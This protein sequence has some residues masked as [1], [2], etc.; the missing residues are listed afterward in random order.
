MP[1]IGQLVHYVAEGGEHRPAWVI[2]VSGGEN[3]II[4]YYMTLGNENGFGLH[5]GCT[6]DEST[7]AVDTWHYPE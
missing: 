2:D 5:G 4:I 1:E 7:K 3:A 6:H